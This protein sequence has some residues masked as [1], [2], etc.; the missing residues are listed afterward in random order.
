MY[1]VFPVLNATLSQRYKRFR[2]ETASYSVCLY[3]GESVYHDPNHYKN[4]SSP[5]TTE[6][7]TPSKVQLRSIHSQY[8]LYPLLSDP[9]QNPRS[10]ELRLGRHPSPSGRH[11]ARTHLGKQPLQRLLIILQKPLQA[12]LCTSSPSSTSEM[13]LTGEK[14]IEGIKTVV[15]ETT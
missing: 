1:I 6:I 10:E 13:G 9:L 14:V 11:I 15:G 8:S 12:I 5:L 7:A 4:T 3:E 2:G